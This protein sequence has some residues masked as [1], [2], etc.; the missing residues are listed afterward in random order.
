MVATRFEEA[1]EAM[2][3]LPCPECGPRNVSEFRYIGEA[4]HRP[5]PATATAREWRDYLYF[6]E[7]PCGWQREGWF[8]R[9]GCRQ[10]FQVERDTSTNTVRVETDTDWSNVEGAA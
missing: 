9:A 5:D 2:M 3:L 1:S 6:R 10:Y 8:H 7:N 4:V